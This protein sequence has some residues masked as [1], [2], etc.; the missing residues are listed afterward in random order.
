MQVH[1]ELLFEVAAEQLM[2]AA[3]LV[4]ECM[5]GAMR[6]LKQDAML[7]MPVKLASGPSWGQLTPYS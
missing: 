4:K 5:E 2:Q 7:P 3:A 1:D 6:H